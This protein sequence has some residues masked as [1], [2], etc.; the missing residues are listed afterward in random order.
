MALNVRDHSAS[1]NNLTNNSGVDSTSSTPFGASKHVV[2]LTPSSSYLNVA[3]DTS[4][5]MQTGHFTVEFWIKTSTD[6][7]YAAQCGGFD[8]AGKG[9]FFFITGGKIRFYSN[10]HTGT[11]PGTDFQFV[12][13][14]STVTDGNW[15]HIA[16]VYDATNLKIYFDGTNEA[17]VA[18][19]NNAVYNSPNYGIIGARDNSGTP[20]TFVSALM[21]EFRIWSTDRSASQIANNRSVQLVGNEANLVAYYP[22]EQLTGIDLD[23]SLALGSA[24]ATSLTV[25]YT[26]TGSNVILYVG[27]RGTSGVSNNISG[28][29]YNGVS[30]TKVGEIQ[31]P[32]DRWCSLWRLLNAPT[33]AHNIVINSSSSDYI[34]GVAVS[35][36]NVKGI[37]TQ[38]TNTATAA[39]SISKSLTTAVD[40]DW[41]VAVA[42]QN[43]TGPIS[44]GSNTVL[45]QLSSAVNTM[46]MFDSTIPISP[47]GSR[48]LT[49]NVGS[50]TANL[51]IIMEAFSPTGASAGGGAMLFNF[52]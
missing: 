7:A 23:T 10:K 17:N 36:V 34:E 35:Y 32:S 13:S 22:F 41:A 47:P 9:W 24:T 25:S 21:D 51:A 33:G 1:N 38:G 28:V 15:H 26:V 42:F 16:G 30:L 20:D 6:S 44:A 2:D 14:V 18:W 48:T 19:S 50:G 52:L 40:L 29:T 8:T 49:A 37:D 5:W 12:E 43:G 3:Q 4:A 27:V 31:A 46:A 39:S 45:R 11:T